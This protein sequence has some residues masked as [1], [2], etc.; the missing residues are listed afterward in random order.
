MPDQLY[1]DSV[2][3]DYRPV[4]DGIGLVPLLG[5][6]VVNAFLAL[7]P[8]GITT[9]TVVAVRPDSVT[10]GCGVIAGNSGGSAVSTITLPLILMCFRKREA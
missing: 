9:P 3:D 1:A 7:N 10:A 2:N 8:E 6:G 5:S 4:E